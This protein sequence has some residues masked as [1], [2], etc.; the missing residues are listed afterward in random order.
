[1]ACAAITLLLSS[2][3]PQPFNWPLA[4]RHEAVAQPKQNARSKQG[5]PP[6]TTTAEEAQRS[7]NAEQIA[8]QHDENIAV[9]GLIAKYTKEVALYTDKLANFTL[10]LAVVTSVLVGVGALQALLAYRLWQTSVAQWKTYEATLA[11]NKTVSRAYVSMSHYPS[12]EQDANVTLRFHFDR[13]GPGRAFARVRIKNYGQTPARIESV[14]L[15]VMTVPAGEQLPDRPN[16]TDPR[17]VGHFLVRN[18]RF[19]HSLAEELSRELVEDVLNGRRDA[20]LVGFIDYI[21]T[22]EQRHRSRR[23]DG[24]WRT[25]AEGYSGLVP[26]VEAV[27]K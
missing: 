2:Y 19:D 25:E 14:A 1:M 9:Q 16:Y 26:V 22:F 7:K 13:D 3:L 4:G 27:A 17:P 18:D 10:V 8:R 6:S 20:L 23:P 15:G 12:Y 21:D 11:A 24:R 5:A